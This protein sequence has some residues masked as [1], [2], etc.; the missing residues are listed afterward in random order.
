MKKYSIYVYDN[1]LASLITSF[2]CQVPILAS[3]LLLTAI[4]IHL[5]EPFCRRN[6][7]QSLIGSLRFCFDVLP[8][9]LYNHSNMILTL[10]THLPLVPHMCVSELGKHWFR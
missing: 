3:D 2:T 10:S 1:V 7:G 9:G 5:I 6:S 4:N 8:M